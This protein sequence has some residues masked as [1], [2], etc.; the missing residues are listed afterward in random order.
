MFIQQINNKNCTLLCEA[1]NEYNTEER[2][3]F[4]WNENEQKVRYS[5][6]VAH[7]EDLMSIN[8]NQNLCLFFLNSNRSIEMKKTS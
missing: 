7:A 6:T 1:F 4:E 5:A 2:K 3:T 8:F